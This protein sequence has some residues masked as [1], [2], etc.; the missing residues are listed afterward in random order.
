M[1]IAFSKAARTSLASLTKMTYQSTKTQIQLQ[2]HDDERQENI[3]SGIKCNLISSLGN[4]KET[5]KLESHARIWLDIQYSAK[6]PYNHFLSRHRK[7]TSH[8]M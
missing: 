3:R 6:G 8:S 4:E 5:A 7:F 2:V 1:L